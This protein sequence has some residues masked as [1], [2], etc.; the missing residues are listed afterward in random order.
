M[1]E[2]SIHPEA[3]ARQA[4]LTVGGAQFDHIRH[5]VAVGRIQS[6]RIAG[7]LRSDRKCTEHRPPSRDVRC[8]PEIRPLSRTPSVERPPPS[9]PQ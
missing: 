5:F 8:C 7:R 4:E 2:S 3:A 9:P 6:V 1:P